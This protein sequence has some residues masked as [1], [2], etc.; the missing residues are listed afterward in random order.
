MKFNSEVLFLPDSKTK[1]SATSSMFH[2]AYRHQPK[3]NGFFF[4]AGF[5]FTSFEE[6]LPNPIPFSIGFGYG[7]K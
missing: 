2:I 5:Q 4:Q 3:N 6:D 1:E 7:F